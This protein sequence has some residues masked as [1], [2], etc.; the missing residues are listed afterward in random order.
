MKNDPVIDAIREVRHRISASV[1]HDPQRLVE[2]YQ[3]RQRKSGKRVL[4]HADPSAGDLEKA[5]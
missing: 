4:L 1:N 2:Y 3:Q 5:T